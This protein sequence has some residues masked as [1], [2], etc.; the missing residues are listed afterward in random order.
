VGYVG[1]FGRHLANHREINVVP[2]GTFSQ[3]TVNGVD[4]S[5]PT[6]RAALDDSITFAERPYPA[7][8]SIRMWEYASTSNYHSLQATL[9]QQTNSR[10]QYFLTYTFSKAL[11]SGTVNETDGSGGLDPYDARNRTWGVLPTDRTHL[12]NLSYNWMVPDLVGETSGGFLKGLLNNWQISGISTFQSGQYI[13]LR[14]DSDLGPTNADMCLAWKG[15]RTAAGVQQQQQRLRDADH[16]R[17]SQ[18]GRHQPGRSCS[19]SGRSA[20]RPSRVGAS[21]TSRST[22][23]PPTACSTTSRS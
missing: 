7:Y 6:N 19:T 9:S 15:H 21:T 23:A 10:L 20:F 18:R 14:F 22:S 16:R 12:A 11:G 4:L 2:L 5:V 13:R 17:R 3:G 1:T 8:G